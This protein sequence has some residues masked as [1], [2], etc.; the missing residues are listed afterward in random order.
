MAEQAKLTGPDFGAGVDA[1]TVRDGEPVLGHA[2]GEAVLLVRRG[3]DF[4]AI[5]ATCTHYGGPL[6]E[7][8]IDGDEVRC[9]W[10]HACFNLRTGEALRSPALSPVACWIVERRQEKI[11]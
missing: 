10:H 2:N 4:L 5:S 9:P 3:D 11:F 6:A 8:R 1:S 7:G